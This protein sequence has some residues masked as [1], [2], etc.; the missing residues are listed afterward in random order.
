LITGLAIGLSLLTVN[1][2][3]FV[4]S[5]HPELLVWGYT[6]GADGVRTLSTDRVI[7]NILSLSILRTVFCR[8]CV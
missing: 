4:M 7:T 1:L 2:D 8:T 5:E 3:H 6:G